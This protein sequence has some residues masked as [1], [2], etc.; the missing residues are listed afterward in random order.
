MTALWRDLL[1]LLSIGS[2]VHGRAAMQQ[3]G[4]E[5]VLSVCWHPLGVYRPSRPTHMTVR[6]ELPHNMRPRLP[7]RSLDLL[8]VLDLLLS[9]LFAPCR[10][11]VDQGVAG[12]LLHGKTGL[13]GASTRQSP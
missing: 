10:C 6:T 2:R 13:A 5:R 12:S 4:M 3:R 9:H 11:G 8:R 7:E 1:L